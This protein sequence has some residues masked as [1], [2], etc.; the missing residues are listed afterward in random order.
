MSVWS[1]QILSVILVAFCLSVP[2]LASLLSY[3]LISEETSVDFTFDVSG[4]QQSGTMPIESAD[5]RIDLN[6]LPNSQV[7]VI[8]NVAKART[9]L[10][11]ARKPMLGESV[12]NADAYPTIRFTSTRIQLGSEGRISHGA[13]I[14]GDLTVRGVTRP[15]TLNAALYRPPGSAP[16]DLDALSI[17]LTGA[18]DR[19]A[20]GA[21][22]YPDLVDD[23]VAL[24]I[25]AEII[26]EN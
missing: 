17:R 18:L 4:V 14:T 12:L 26:R 5:I 19:H 9:R 15:V 25:H 2:A 21:S 3:E 11:F 1:R 10:P 7:D 22:G 20:Y 13:T 23:T 6:D 16:D 8:L 24:D